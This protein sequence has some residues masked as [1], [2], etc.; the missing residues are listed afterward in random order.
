MNEL[1]GLCAVDDSYFVTVEGS[2][3]T[4]TRTICLY[5]VPT[6]ELILLDTYKELTPA[7][8]PRA[9]RSGHIYVPHDD[10]VAVFRIVENRLHMDRNLRGGDS[11]S[12]TSVFG[13]A[14]VNDTTL[15]V[16]V[17]YGGNRG[18]YLLDIITDTVLYALH[19]PEIH[20]NMF[21]SGVSVLG[22]RILVAYNVRGLVLYNPD[23]SDGVQLDTPGLRRMNGMTVD[24]A[25]RFLV[26]DEKSNTVW[27]L[28]VT[29]KVLA[30]VESDQPVDVT[31]SPDNSKMYIGHSRS[32]EI[33]VLEGML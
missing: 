16:T 9:D 10:G 18:V 11:G 4:T 15:C 17:W 8:Y 24:P 5:Q 12:L 23:E 2:L 31:L 29:G 26:A 19:P 28:S 25:G 30:R 33:T 14:V 7:R 20:D 13:V 22:G 1:L 21:P 32:G 27:V 6:D 3:E